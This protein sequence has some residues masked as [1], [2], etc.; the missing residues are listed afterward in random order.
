[1]HDEVATRM[2]AYLQM[3][4]SL[5]SFFLTQP[6]YSSW[7]MSEELRASNLQCHFPF[8][9]SAFPLKCDY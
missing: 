5:Q 2:F 3:P 9:R 7:L 8:A 4:S 1:M 6:L